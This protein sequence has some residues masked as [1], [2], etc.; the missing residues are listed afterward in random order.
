LSDAP[1][2]VARYTHPTEAHIARMKL[3][4]EGVPVFMFSANLASANWLLSG[5]LGGIRLQVPPSELA[6]A[7]EI[8]GN[9]DEGAPSATCPACGSSKVRR[10]RFWWKMAFLSVHFFSIPLPF[11]TG[12]LKCDECGH[13]WDKASDT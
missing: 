10:A 9:M 12:E 13:E 5:A 1:I 4:S 2:T 11:S 6:R 8:L 3:E 7:R